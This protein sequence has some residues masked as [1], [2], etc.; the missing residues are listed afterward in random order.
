MQL[1]SRRS[2]VLARRGMVATSQPLGA[3][4]GLRILMQGG[5]AIDAAVATAAA[6]NVVEPMSTG[7]GGDAFALVWMAKEKQVR[8][9]NA[10]GRAPAGASIEEL[11]RQGITQIP[12]QSA[13]AVSVPGAVN[14]WHSILQACGTMPL[15][16]VLKPAIEY[17]EEGYPVSNVIAYQWDLN[18]PKLAQ[19]PSGRELLLNG[20]APKEGDV[21]RLPELAKTLRSIAEGGPEAFYKGPVAEKIARYVQEEGGWLSTEDLANDT[22]TW[23]EPVYT[24]YRGVRCWEC[25]PNGQGLIAL[26]ALNIVEGFD[27]R[28]MGPQSADTYHHLIEAIRIAFADGL[29]YIADPRATQVPTSELLSKSYARQRGALIRKDQAFTSVE[30]GKVPT[31]HDTVYISCV[32]GQGNACSFINSVFQG[33]GTGLVVPGTGIALQNRAALFSLDPGHPNA[34]TPGK[35]PFHTIIPAM[36]TRDGELWLT[37]GVMGAFQQP[38]GHLQVLVNMIDFGLDP[39]EALNALRFSVG[40]DGS[41]A[42]EE[43]VSPEVYRGLERRGHKVDIVSGYQRLKF[44]GGQVIERNPETGVLIAGSEP[45]KDGVAVGW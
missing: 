16:E 31:L 32:D 27:L 19:R 14:G 29:H 28:S 2:P 39:Q 15:S 30:F 17:A 33:F 8:A 44:G 25:P 36:A 34:L 22:S 41:V 42:L 20:G 23:D 18:V 38:Q 7:V 13:Y 24:D 3:M 35:R 45:R 1:N 26:I 40:L 37:Y 4:A 5:N 21:M 9:I 6:L 43:G 10:S 11:S 12:P